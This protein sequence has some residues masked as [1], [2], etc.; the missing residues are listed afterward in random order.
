MDFKDIKIRYKNSEIK[1][2]TRK[3][4]FVT[5]SC[6]IFF[7]F[8]FLSLIHLHVPDTIHVKTVLMHAYTDYAASIYFHSLLPRT[9]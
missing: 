5:L 6:L 3:D 8:L 7:F 9:L 4:E 1:I 2:G